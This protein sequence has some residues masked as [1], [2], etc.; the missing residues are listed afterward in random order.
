[1]VLYLQ[2]LFVATLLSY[3]LAS[4]SFVYSPFLNTKRHLVTSFLSISKY[5]GPVP[6]C[7]KTTP[8]FMGLIESI[9]SFLNNREGDFVK[10]ESSEAVNGPGPCIILYGCPPGI[11]NEEIKDM[12]SDGAPSASSNNGGVVLRRITASSFLLNRTV[13]EALEEVVVEGSSYGFDD[14]K[15][16]GEQP[17][18]PVIYFCGIS[19]DEMMA[20]Y[21]I[22]SSQIYE[23]TQG[24]S[25]AACTRNLR[26]RRRDTF[27]Y[28]LTI[29]FQK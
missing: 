18:C 1:M 12:I 25:K 21:K 20:T 3:L 17:I 5:D 7:R 9:S 28:Q 24:L 14:S 2:V 6:N 27:L 22:I 13:L 11:T 10:L 26:T 8:L 23:E 19:N 16:P 4:H 15:D 29:I